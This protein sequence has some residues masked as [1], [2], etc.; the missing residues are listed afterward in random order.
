MLNEGDLKSTFSGG[1]RTSNPFSINHLQG[2]FKVKLQV[3]QV[4]KLGLF[5]PFDKIPQDF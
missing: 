5:I 3:F 2:L 1:V 4:P